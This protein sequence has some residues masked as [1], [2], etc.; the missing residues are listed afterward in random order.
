MKK[1]RISVVKTVIFKN[2]NEIDQQCQNNESL[3]LRIC[4][5]PFENKTMVSNSLIIVDFFQQRSHYIHN[6][7]FLFHSKILLILEILISNFPFPQSK[8]KRKN[9]IKRKSIQ[10]ERTILKKVRNSWP[11]Q[12]IPQV[13]KKPFFFVS[14]GNREENVQKLQIFLSSLKSSRKRAQQRL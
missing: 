6:L 9:Y 8:L 5:F 11:F 10:Q 1:W 7:T 13:K 4:L 2:S 12:P 14:S 3:K